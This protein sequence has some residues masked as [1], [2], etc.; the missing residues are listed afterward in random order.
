[1][2]ESKAQAKRRVRDAKII[3]LYKEYWREGT[4]R[5]VSLEL[6]ANKLK[7]SISTAARVTSHLKID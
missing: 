5:S 2:V 4:L 6:I 7:I 1:M 3:E